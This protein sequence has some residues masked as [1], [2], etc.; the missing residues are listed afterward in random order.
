MG[1]LLDFL[2]LH[3]D[4]MTY[5]EFCDYDAD[6]ARFCESLTKNI[7]AQLSFNKVVAERLNL[8]HAAGEPLRKSPAKT[9]DVAFG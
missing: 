2:F 9:E 7:E 1:R 8:T 6:M 5:S 3:L 4:L